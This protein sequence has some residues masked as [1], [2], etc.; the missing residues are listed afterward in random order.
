[1][2]DTNKLEIE[3]ALMAAAI[4]IAD[5]TMVVMKPRTRASL[6]LKSES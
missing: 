1:V 2:T 5:A 6:L 4:A 3:T